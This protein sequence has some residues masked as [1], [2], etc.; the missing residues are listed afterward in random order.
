MLAR[1]S[2]EGL[3]KKVTVELRFADK[4]T[5]FAKMSERKCPARG[6]SRCRG[7]EA[8]IKIL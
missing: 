1:V 2:R 3:S 5:N 8:G 7:L 4:K 6:N